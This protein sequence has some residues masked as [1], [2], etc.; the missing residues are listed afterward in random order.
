[1]RISAGLA[2]ACALTAS[3]VQA[4]PRP[5]TIDDQLS[6]ED[7]GRVGFSPDGR[8]LLVERYGRYRDLPNYDHE[9]Y[10]HQSASRLLVTDLKAGGAPRALL[11]D[12]P[13]AGDTF[14]AFS[15]DG[16]RVLVFRLKDHRRELG[17]ATLATGAVVWSGL[18]ADPEIWTAQA[19]WR[20][21]RQ[22]V[23]IARPPDAP[24]MLLG[25]GWQTQARTKAAWVAAGHGDYSGVVLGAGRY[26]NLNAAPPQYDLAVLDAETGKSRVLA[27][28]AFLDMLI[29]P[30]RRTVA[31][32]REAELT[33]PTGGGIIRLSYP[34]R[35]RRLLLVDLDSGA[36]ARP[37]PACDLAQAMWVWSPDSKAVIA[38]ARDQ[39]AFDAA[40]GYWRLEASGGA[41]P[42]APNLR[43]G[44]VGSGAMAVPTGQAAWLG[45]DPVVLAQPTGTDRFDWW[46]LTAKGPIKLTAGF[47]PPQGPA[48][49]A[50]AK[51]V[52]ISTASGLVRLPPQGRAVVVAPPT[53]QWQPARGLPGQ[54]TGLVLADDAGRGRLLTTAGVEG[55]AA[56]APKDTALKAFSSTGDV[57]AVARDAHGVRTLALCRA[58]ARTQTL[59]TINADL[60]DV[61]FSDPVPIKHQGANGEILTSWLYV[62]PDHKPT[63]ER[64]VV[65][66]PYTGDRYDRPPSYYGPGTVFPTVNVQLLVAQ[67]YAVVA[68]SL[69]V[70]P[71]AEPGA[72][73]ADAILKVADAARAQSPGLSSTRLAL[74]G[75]SF[76][77][78]S[79]LMAGSQ[80]PRFKALIATAP[81]T[82]LVTFHSALRP[83]S[84][85]V[86][87]VGMSLTNMAGWAEGGQGRMGAPPWVAPERYARNS[88]LM[89]ADTITAPVMLVYGDMD[90]DRTQVTAMFTS[91]SR[92]GKDVQLLYYRGEN[93]MIIGPANV[94]DLYQRAFAFLAD[95]LGPAAGPGTAA[96]AAPAASASR[97]SQ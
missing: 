28:G 76:G 81:A 8:W 3:P 83:V 34:H 20:D 70:A 47:E 40:Y 29:S 17:V 27:R 25:A 56:T 16:T 64:A 53:V 85:A 61:Q 71:G 95:T 14:G 69:P 90:F 24:S 26:A 18:A 80:S 75:Q 84:L 67:G 49:A 43:V 44:L 63:D 94:R 73:L 87:E 9:A 36:T 65:I 62:P 72:G 97:P 39:P 89:H 22:V 96:G 45:P 82:D 19:R 15:P 88:P 51:G 38:A 93:H 33:A 66:V 2:L 54:P 31:L 41:T 11:A 42:L 92:Q 57:A 46:R 77:G 59:A 50:D 52:L 79:A 91:L 21:D 5:F 74:W 32:S 58:K 86:P 78:W 60:A 1:M 37:C 7:F 4:A 23:V 35:R 13:R 68:P 10:G 12:D 48:L 30:D 55:L 6:L